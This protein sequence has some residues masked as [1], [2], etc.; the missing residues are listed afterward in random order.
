MLGLRRRLPARNRLQVRVIKGAGVLRGSELPLRWT[1]WKKGG[2]LR[3]REREGG[4]NAIVRMADN[5]A[6]CGHADI[7]LDE[8]PFMEFVSRLYSAWKVR[9]LSLAR[10]RTQ[11]R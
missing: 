5:G 3:R 7:E 6:A 4:T 9:S 11:L 2:R 8:A 1:R 10:A